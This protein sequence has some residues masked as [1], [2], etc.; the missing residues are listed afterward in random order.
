M[1]IEFTFSL[2][3]GY[4]FKIYKFEFGWSAPLLFLKNGSFSGNYK[5]YTGPNAL[6]LP[7]FYSLNEINI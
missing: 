5:F 7:A 2:F 3:S 4:E 1:F 6:L